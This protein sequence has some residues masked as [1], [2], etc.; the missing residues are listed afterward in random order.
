MIYHYFNRLRE[1]DMQAMCE[2]KYWEAGT[3]STVKTLAAAAVAM[4]LIQSKS[5]NVVKLITDDQVV[6]S[7][8]ESSSR[9]ESY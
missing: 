8:R 9:G 2:H 6:T 5:S 4:D 7:A 3:A 1:R